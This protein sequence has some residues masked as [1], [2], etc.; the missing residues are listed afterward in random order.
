MI[1]SEL[2]IEQ[3]QNKGDIPAHVVSRLVHESDNDAMFFAQKI[4]ESGYLSRDDIGPILGNTM[5]IAYLNLETTLF[6]DDLIDLLPKDLALK[7][8]AIPVY[9]IGPA[10]T[11]AFSNPIDVE[12]VNMIQTLLGSPVESV[13]SF[14]EEITS[15]IQVNYHRN[16]ELENIAIN[17]NFER[18]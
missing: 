13:F 7:Y 18:Y 10:I 6:H 1:L 5:N 15:A 8:N 16:E 2:I 11:V 3:V 4:I 9:K 12:K 17:F 14:P